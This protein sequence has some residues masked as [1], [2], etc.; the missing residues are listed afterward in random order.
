MKKDSHI[1]I[2][3]A[4]L[5]YGGTERVALNLASYFID[6]GHKVTIVTTYKKDDEMPF[7][8]AAARVVTE[9]EDME[10]NEG[11]IANFKKRL[12]NLKNVWLQ[13]QPNVILSFIGK[14]N[15]MAL[16]STRNLDIPVYIAVR[17]DPEAEYASKAMRIV[18]KTLFAKAAGIILQTERSKKYFPS[19]I[20]KK[21]RILKN[22]ISAAYIENNED[23]HPEKTVVTVGRCDDNKNQMLIIRAFMSLRAKY[24]NYKLIIYGD[25]PK[26]G[27]LIEYVREHELDD[28][29]TLPGITENTRESIKNAGIFVLSSNSEG[30]PNALIEAMAL[31]IPSIST[32][33]PCGGPAEL[34]KDGVNGYLIPVADEK[35]L[36]LAMDKLMGNSDLSEAIGRE[37]Q[38]IK[39]ELLPE[40]VNKEWEEYICN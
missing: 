16:L 27:E 31:G 21:C 9:P 18:S 8:E 17:G 39:E 24:P 32:D 5:P 20:R 3:L 2:Y 23:R 15:M 34:I 40:K 28:C 7:P 12:S 38:K 11:R 10:F 26:R 25:G 30:M 6:T 22:P 13:I 36:A 33:C 14:N 19:Y 1:A 4:A 37:A 35:A 29:I